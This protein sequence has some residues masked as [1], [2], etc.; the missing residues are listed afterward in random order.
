M[1]IHK[2]TAADV[3][4]YMAAQLSH[5]NREHKGGSGGECDRWKFGPTYTLQR[6]NKHLCNGWPEGVER[7]RRI[8]AD[9]DARAAVTVRDIRRRRVRGESGAEVDVTAYWRG[10]A[11]I[12]WERCRRDA[13]VKARAVHIV[14]MLTGVC[15]LEADQFFYRGAA[16]VRLCDLLAAAGY[17]VAVTAA[18]IVPQVGD[19]KPRSHDYAWG[20]PLKPYNAPLEINALTAALCEV[21][22]TRHYV[23][24]HLGTASFRVGAHCG[25]YDQPGI[26]RLPG[27]AR[28]AVPEQPG[29]RTVYLP[30]GIGTAAQAEEWVK[31]QLAAIE[32]GEGA[33]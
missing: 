28:V 32:A 5:V 20:I 29:E 11:D 4:D 3:Q 21:G 16:A 12:A 7:V 19:M 18:A 22:F 24:R 31:A 2:G 17:S 10:R 13:S 23:F 8:N 14:P 27:L 33:S 1:A 26:A 30:Y 25:W 9:A 6:L 15:T